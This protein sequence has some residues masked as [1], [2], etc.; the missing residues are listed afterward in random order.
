MKKLSSKFQLLG[1]IICVFLLSAHSCRSQE[2]EKELNWYDKSFYILH[3]DHHTRNDQL[4]GK[5]A[6]FDE[7]LRL[8]KLSNPDVI[9]IH[10]KGRPGYTTYPSLVGNVPDSLS[11]DVLRVW[12]DLSLE[13]DVPFSIY[14]N[15]GRDG[16]LM[17]NNPWF[18]RQRPDGSLYAD[19]LCYNSG[20]DTAYLFPMITEIMEW[21]KPNG[22]WFDGYIFTA[23]SCYCDRCREDFINTHHMEVPVHPSAPGWE[24]YKEMQREYTRDLIHRTCDLIHSIDPECLVCVNFAYSIRMPEK[25]YDGIAYLDG[26]IG[27]NITKLSVLSKFYGT[28]G[29]PFNLMTPIKHGR[30]KMEDHQQQEIAVMIAHGGRFSAW[31]SPTR[32][33][34]LV[35][36]RQIFLSRIAEWMRER[37]SLTLNS[38]ALPDISVLLVADVHYHNSNDR[39]QCFDKNNI[40]IY[41]ASERLTSNHLLH[42]IIADWRLIEG[43]VKGR[44]IVLENPSVIPDDNIHALSEF[45]KKGGR[46]FLTGMAP[47]S[48]GERIMEMAGIEKISEGENIELTYMDSS[49]S[50]NCYSLRVDKKT[51]VLVEGLS[52]KGEKLPLLIESDYGLGKVYYVPFPFY[53]MSYDSVSPISNALVQ[54]L[55]GYVFPAE[56]L[57]LTTN[58]PSEVEISLRKNGNRKIIHLVNRSTGEDANVDSRELIH[59]HRYDY[60]NTNFPPAGD[61]QV[62]LKR[63]SRPA[64]VYA[65]PGKLPVKWD[66][67]NGEIHVEVPLFPVHLMIVVND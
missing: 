55:H 10:A 67:H 31:D 57:S 59:G 14:Y 52:K 24:L 53:T 4:A 3:I 36:E 9:Q 11:G 30:G 64:S 58:A 62:S 19:A 32:E 56:I 12:K 66:Y 21:Y 44:T 47:L 63:L 65:E 41:A 2:E 25:P 38:E 5:D 27:G 26:D 8:L 22:F 34:A 1:A 29:K 40:E 45:T 20:V 13:L 18:N 16:Y 37:E 51:R 43:P 48:G 28:Q 35:E 33:S 61:F 23:S 50:V 6:D 15:L 39:H 17:K 54:E 60:I 46:L 42:D 7:T 49:H